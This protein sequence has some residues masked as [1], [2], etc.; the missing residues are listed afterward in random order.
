M[1]FLRKNQFYIL[2]GLAAIVL[3]PIVKKELAKT[4]AKK[5]AAE[6]SAANYYGQVI[7]NDLKKNNPVI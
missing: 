3:Y 1:N 7:D 4:K 2:L 5:T 6:V